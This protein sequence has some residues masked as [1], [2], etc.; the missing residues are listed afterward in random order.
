MRD[1]VVYGEGRLGEVFKEAGLCGL[2]HVS[3]GK[4]D[5][6]GIVGSLTGMVR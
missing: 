2:G 3:L 1:A 6:G 4:L 5:A